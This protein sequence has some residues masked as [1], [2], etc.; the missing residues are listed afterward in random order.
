MRIVIGPDDNIDLRARLGANTPAPGGQRYT[1]QNTGSRRCYLGEGATVAAVDGWS[2]LVP[3]A[4]ARIALPYVDAEGDPTLWLRC[5]GGGNVVAE[6]L[7]G[8]IE[9]LP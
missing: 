6:A 7:P 8:A 3:D 2:E 4:A 1:L 5:P 9:L